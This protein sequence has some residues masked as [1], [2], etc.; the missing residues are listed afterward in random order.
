MY[1]EDMTEGFTYETGEKS[2]TQ[3]EII[4][5]A[6]QWDAQPFHL[7]EEAA[8]A[9]PYGRIIASGFHTLLT[10][11]NLTLAASDWSDSSMGSPGMDEIRWKA[12]VYPGDTLKVRAT[13]LKATASRSKPDRGFVD[14]FNEIINQSG[15]VVAS[16]KA[17]HMLKRR[18]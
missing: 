10:A 14:V 8:K 16:Y 15:A 13:V 2:L 1:F 5:F 7:D 17:T 6:K 11:F 3:E 12:P 4:T 18:G 9:S